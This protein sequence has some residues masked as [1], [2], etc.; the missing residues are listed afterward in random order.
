[1][2]NLSNYIE[3]FGFLKE[4]DNSAAARGFDTAFLAWLCAPKDLDR[5]D[6]VLLAAYYD[7]HRRTPYPLLPEFLS[8][9]EKIYLGGYG[10]NIVKDTY[11]LL[12]NENGNQS[13][14]NR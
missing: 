4:G 5:L 7:R 10:C 6:A 12:K 9:A 3:T 2:K 8:Y 11:N 1:M 14:A 13:C